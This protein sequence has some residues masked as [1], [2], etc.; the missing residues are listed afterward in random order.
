[1]DKA[2]LFDEISANIEQFHH[3]DSDRKVLYSLLEHLNKALEENENLLKTL[4][5]ADRKN[6]NL[7]LD[8]ARLSVYEKIYEDARPRPIQPWE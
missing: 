3:N 6:Y 7:H 1:M 4:E 8:V 5:D 2:K